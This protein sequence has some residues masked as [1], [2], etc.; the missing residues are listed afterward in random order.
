VV[1]RLCYWLSKI[2]TRL[3]FNL[4]VIGRENLICRGGCIIASNHL[5][6]LDPVILGAGSFRQ[7]D[8]MAKKSLFRNKLFS[9]FI[10]SVGAF[11]VGEEHVGPQG[12]KEALK[13]LAEGKVIVLFPEGTRSESGNLQEGKP[14]IGLLALESKVPVIPA[15]VIGTDKALPIGAKSI[16]PTPI[17]VYFGQPLEFSEF[18]QQKKKRVNYLKVSQLVIEKISRLGPRNE[19]SNG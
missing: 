2:L 12:I 13:R 11:A 5:S 8:F 16:R 7:L 4:K 18:Y 10:S 1:Y 15:R 17:S 14:G 3:L 6:Y 19:N 9:R